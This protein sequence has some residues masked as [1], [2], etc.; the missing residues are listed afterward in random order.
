MAR[1]GVRIAFTVRTPRQAV[2]R[3]QRVGVSMLDAIKTEVE[4]SKERVYLAALPD[5][6]VKSGYMRDTLR[7]ESDE[8]GLGYA[9]G[10]SAA[11]YPSGGKRYTYATSS[12]ILASAKPPVVPAGFYP[13]F[14]VL[15]TRF[16]AGRDP[17]TPA[18]EAERPVFFRALQFA[19]SGALTR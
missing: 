10:W 6:P 3:L 9:V 15:G 19:I 16:K 18:L 14:V 4:A 7:R 5:V 2:A 11:D 13:G 8:D 12:A 17:I 1:S